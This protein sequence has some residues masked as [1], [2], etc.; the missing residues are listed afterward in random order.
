MLWH[1]HRKHWCN[2]ADSFLPLAYSLASLRHLKISSEAWLSK[3]RYLSLKTSF[4]VHD[5]THYTHWHF[6]CTLCTHTYT[7]THTGPSPHF[8]IWTQD[9]SLVCLLHLV[10]ELFRRQAAIERVCE[11]ERWLLCKCDDYGK[12]VSGTMHRKTVDQERTSV[13]FRHRF[14]WQHHSNVYISHQYTHCII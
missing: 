13:V 14:N 1:R 5:Q 4:T 6:S 7:R 8:L 2:I 10:E 3:T 9:V 11:C 12:C